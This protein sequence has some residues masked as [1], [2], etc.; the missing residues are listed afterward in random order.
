V[1]SVPE[2]R[3]CL[4]VGGAGGIGQAVCLRL[5]K[6]GF[7][8][9][10]A[11]LNIEGALR[12]AANLPGAGH[13]AEQ[14]DVTDEADVAAVF[15]RIEGS[16]PAAVLA[17]LAGRPLNDP[18]NPT[19][20]A[21]MST[22]EWNRTLTLNLTGVFFCVRKFA[23]Q[24]M[25]KPLEHMRIVT[26]G[27]ITGQ[28]GKSSTGIAYATSKAAV[29]GFTRQ[30]AS[31]LAPL[32]VTVNSLAPGAVGTPE[33]FRLTTEAD[34]A[35]IRSRIPLGRMATINEIASAVAFLVSEG[36][37]YITGTTIDVN[38]GLNMR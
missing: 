22:S 36:G 26:F 32:G 7:N 10:V 35:S 31:E 37:A 14:V 2:K 12:T 9:I 20:V 6:D 27:S 34:R 33:F 3:T 23:A 29:I 25:A 13:G 17:V 38:G 1:K 11:D 24:R 21:S 5:A 8:V 18:D 28:V 19:T 16:T 4:V 30:V 15:D